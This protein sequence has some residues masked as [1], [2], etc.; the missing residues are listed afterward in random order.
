MA[1]RIRDQRVPL[2]VAITSN[3]NTS[4]FPSA[5]EHP[6]GALYRGGF[7]VSINTDNRLMSGIT[8]TDE[9][10]LAASTFDLVPADLSAITTAALEAGFGDWPTRSRLIDEVV[11]PAYVRAESNQAPTSAST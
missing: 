3:L 4:A 6:L 1:R 11:R 9:Y 8:L 10:E 2:E 7:N 5:A